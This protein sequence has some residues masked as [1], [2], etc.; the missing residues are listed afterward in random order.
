MIWVKKPKFQT[1]FVS[2][3]IFKTLFKEEPKTMILICA[4]WTVFGI[5]P[6]I[7]ILILN[8][9]YNSLYSAVESRIYSFVILPLILSILYSFS[10]VITGII[11][12]R[13]IELKM[14]DKIM[15]IMS[16][17]FF[18]KVMD[19]NYS[20]F[21]D[22]NYYNILTRARQIAQND[23]V[24]QYI[25]KIFRISGFIL[26]I[27]SQIVSIFIIN[28]LLFFF[29]LISVLPTAVIRIIRGKYYFVLK[30]YQTPKMNE[31]NYLWSLICTKTSS[32]DLHVFDSSSYIINKWMIL[33]QQLRDEENRFMKK[34]TLIQ[35]ATD[36]LKI[37]GY[38][39]GIIYST[40]LLFYHMITSAI[41]AVCIN[42]FIS[43]QQRFEQCLMYT[44]L[45]SNESEFIKDYFDFLKFETPKTMPGAI[46]EK[47]SLLDFK[48]VSFHYSGDHSKALDE[49][50]FSIK[51][52]NTP[53]V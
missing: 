11:S 17:N 15:M 35:F 37:L 5:L 43:I 18:R 33:S 46:D 20:Y 19:V 41:F 2:V 8:S 42:V 6:G 34:T 4:Y 38:F 49:I 29:A 47:I 23:R 51:K 52:S 45:I 32:R 12:D 27:L 3:K 50:S 16:K 26:E 28:P 1:L 24:Y 30:R 44:A 10:G 21:D 31:Q 9:L 25:I 7:N 22:D 14:P 48:N 36:S 39:L 13:Y 40:Y 53:A